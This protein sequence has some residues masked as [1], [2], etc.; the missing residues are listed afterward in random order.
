M[1]RYAGT[2][3]SELA[4]SE[5]V[6]YATYVTLAAGR[7][8]PPV[9]VH[10]CALPAGAGAE[11][12]LQAASLTKPAVAFATLELVR[13]GMIDL[14]SPVSRYL[15]DGYLHR[16]RPF[17]GPDDRHTDRVPTTTLARIPVS[18][19]LNHSSG[20]PNWSS[21]PLVPEFEPGRRWQYS[22]E[23]YLLLQAVI[24]TVTG[25]SMEAV[26]SRLVLEP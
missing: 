20:L 8:Q 13:A 16:Q 21:D 19:L 6:C 25:E 5:G 24:T 23:G 9:V 7:A 10:G 18:T 2:P 22:G 3:I 17:A 1:S 11:G 4:S 15:P 12:V 14:G 26:V